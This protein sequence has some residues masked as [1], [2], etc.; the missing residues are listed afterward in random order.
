MQGTFIINGGFDQGVSPFD[1]G[2]SYGD[3][4]FR[5]LKIING[6]PID[7]PLHYQRLVSD[8]GAIGIV[9]P[10]A[11][12]LMSDIQNLF[13]PTD[14]AVAKIIVT[15]GEGERGYAPPAVT[16][17]TRIVF[18]SR[19][20]DS[21]QK[22]HREGVRLFV[23]KTTLAYQPYLAGV[24]H[25][26]RLENVIARA[27]WNDPAIFDGV[28]L[29]IEDN[30]VECTSAN[31]FARYGKELH[32]PMI[33]KCGIAGVTRQKV[34]NLAH[35][36]LLKPIVKN[37]KLSELLEADEVIVCNSIY[38][39]LQVRAIANKQWEMNE[40]ASRMRKILAP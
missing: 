25:L 38:S 10:S 26:N 27:E 13:S 7:W 6:L 19:L 36:P 31:I 28:M 35:Q 33:D 9:C 22:C 37:I 17:P 3:G 4:V 18:K 15:R 20:P 5:T 8:C 14:H 39:A 23:C 21:I 29:D 24:K 12:V 16:M 1:R 11:E 2:L 30:V 40:L 32:T 34:I